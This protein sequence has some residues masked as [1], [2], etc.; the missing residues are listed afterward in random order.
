MAG[1]ID[2]TTTDHLRRNPHAGVTTGR[3][4]RVLENW[5]IRGNCADSSGGRSIVHW[6]F[7]PG[8]RRMMRV[9]VSR[10]DKR[11]ITAYQDR[12][13]TSNWNRGTREYFEQRCRDLEERHVGD[14]R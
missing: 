6:G 8:L 3:I 1:G 4:K 11:I 7:V 12:T 10:D 14:S 13:A 2:R 5:V 9:A